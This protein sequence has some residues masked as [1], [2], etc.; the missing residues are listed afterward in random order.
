[1][2]RSSYFDKPVGSTHTMRGPDHITTSS[3]IALTEDLQ[4]QKYSLLVT[5]TLE[6]L[7]FRT[8]AA[9]SSA[10][11]AQEQLGVGPLRYALI[12]GKVYI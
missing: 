6:K 3:L 2:L 9:R 7:P 11:A 5:V 10:S 4:S 1:M 12:P 8:L